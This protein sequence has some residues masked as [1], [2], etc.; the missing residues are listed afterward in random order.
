MGGD[1]EE[2][3]H[4]FGAKSIYLQ[5]KWKSGILLSDAAID[6]EEMLKKAIAMSLEEETGVS[7]AKRE[8]KAE[9]NNFQ[10]AHSQ[11]Q[12]L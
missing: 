7:C 4:L 12:G 2:S 6:E 8:N 3:H 10:V 11:R 1:I 9:S 5:H